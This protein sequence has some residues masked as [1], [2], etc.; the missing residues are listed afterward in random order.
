VCGVFLGALA[1]NRLA[2]KIP[3]SRQVMIGFCLMLSATIGN[4]LY[5]LWFPPALPWSVAPLF[6]YTMGMSMV[7]PGVTLLILDMF[8]D[9]RG[10]VAS[11]QSFTMTMLA[12][13]VSGII[14]PILSHSVLWLAAGQLA[15]TVTAL[16]LWIGARA[17][18]LRL[19]PAKM[20][21]QKSV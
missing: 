3:V 15:F 7:S 19:E 10:I 12:A 9:I 17:R 1:A 14:T 2:G 11:C 16:V 21:S 13:V 20:G 5:H 6:F 8:P 18:T 4:V